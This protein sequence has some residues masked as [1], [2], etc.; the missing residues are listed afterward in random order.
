MGSSEFVLLMAAALTPIR[1][2]ASADDADADEQRAARFDEL[3]ARQRGPKNV[4][5]FFVW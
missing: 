1:P 2:D 3:T 4:D 5:R